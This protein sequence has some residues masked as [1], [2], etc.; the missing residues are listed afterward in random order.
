MIIITSLDFDANAQLVKE[1][2]TCNILMQP[3]KD[4][5]QL[6]A[7]HTPKTTPTRHLEGSQ[8]NQLD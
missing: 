6:N 8:Q 4:L 2:L 3:Q 5:D 1:K 7:L